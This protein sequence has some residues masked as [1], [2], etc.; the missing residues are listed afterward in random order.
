MLKGI[1]ILL[2]TV[3][4]SLSHAQDRATAADTSG[5]QFHF[6]NND[7]A[8]DFGS[9]M[10]NGNSEYRFEFRNSGT[11]PLIIT[12]MR[13]VVKGLNTP[14]YKVLINYPQSPIRPGNKGIITATVVAQG[15]TGS[16]K[17]EVLVNSNAA[18]PNYPLLLLTGAIVPDHGEVVPTKTE[19]KVNLEFLAP[20]IRANTK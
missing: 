8:H 7:R 11:Q 17:C 18:P 9:I 5:P 4:S 1:A 2:F 20:V 6:F 12:G 3:I 14:P 16:F 19:P 15:N 10:I 13:S